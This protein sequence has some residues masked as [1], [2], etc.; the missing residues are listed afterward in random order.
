M[1]TYKDYEKKYIGTSDIAALTVT[2][3]TETGAKAQMVRFGG[4]NSYDAYIV[5]EN[6]E[7]PEH[8]EKVSEFTNWIKIFDDDR[9][10]FD[11]NAKKIEIYRSGNYGCIIRVER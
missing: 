1:K 7:V 2:G 4:D 11:M 10:T 5:D 9:L 3:C 6:C 8:Y